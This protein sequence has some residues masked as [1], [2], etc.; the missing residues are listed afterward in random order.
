LVQFTIM[1]DNHTLLDLSCW[2][3]RTAFLQK[4]ISF[5]ENLRGEPSVQIRVRARVDIRFITS[6][7][8]RPTPAAIKQQGWA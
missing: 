8:Q 4:R 1:N 5:K 2:N 3:H 7:T 6:E